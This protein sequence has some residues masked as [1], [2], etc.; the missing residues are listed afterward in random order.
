ML[1]LE[2]YLRELDSCPDNKLSS[3]YGVYDNF[4]IVLGLDYASSKIKLEELTRLKKNYE[5]T[6]GIIVT[7]F[8]YSDGVHVL[9]LLD[10]K[11]HTYHP[12][13]FQNKIDKNNYGTYF[14]I[15]PYQNSSV[16]NKH[17][18][19]AD[20]IKYLSQ[21]FLMKQKISAFFPASNGTSNNLK[22]LVFYEPNKKL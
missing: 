5:K 12:K 9:R 6:E 21:E 1:K 15:H 16:F 7:E 11:Y 20:M 17:R 18:E 19:M 10:R 3:R 4:P 2:K 22:K 8:N 14:F 13:E